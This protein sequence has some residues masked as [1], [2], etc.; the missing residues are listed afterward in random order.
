MPKIYDIEYTPNPA[1]RKIVL[2]E[3]ITAPGVSLSFSNPQDAAA[4]P[5]AEAL[6]AIPHVKSVFMMDRFITINKDNEVE[7]D[8]LLRQVA[9]PIRAA[10][11]V[12]AGSAPAAP[13]AKRGENPDIDRINDILDARIRP[14]LAGDGGGLEVV[15]YSDNTLAVRYQ[16]ACGSCPSSISGTLYGIQSI[17]RDEFNPELTV[18]AV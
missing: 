9:I 12:T 6:F 3:P 1:A 16:G 10:E 18:I 14:G 15:S 4:H 8:D 7:W 2:K 13:S 5:L 11:P 17:L